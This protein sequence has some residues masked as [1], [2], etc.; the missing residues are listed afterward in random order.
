MKLLFVEN[1]YITWLWRE[2][3]LRLETDGHD[4]HWLVQNPI[5]KPDMGTCHV[6]SFPRAKR[7]AFCTNDRVPLLVTDRAVRYFGLTGDHHTSYQTAIAQVIDA[8]HPDMIFGEPTEFHELIAVAEA[9]RRGIPFLFPSST[10]YPPGRIV[11]QLYDSLSTFGGCGVGLS[12]DDALDLREAIVQRRLVPSY[13]QPTRVAWIT[14][15]VRRIADRARITLGWLAGERFVTPSPWRKI[16]LERARRTNVARWERCAHQALPTDLIGCPLVLY[17]MQVQPESNIDVWGHPWNDQTAIIREAADALQGIGTK[18]VVK[19]NPRSKYEL[20]EDLCR[21]VGTH[22]NIVPLAHGCK[23][24]DVFPHACAVLGVTGTVLL[25]AVLA[26]KPVGV[27]G[28]HPMARYPGVTALSRPSD[29]ALLVTDVLAKRARTAC[30]AEG[31]AL[32]SELHRTSY[33][34]TLFDPL[35]QPELAT[36]ENLDR[37]AN[38]FRDVIATATRPNSAMVAGAPA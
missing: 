21:L 37:I 3:A 20:S 15:Q 33:E 11:F 10:R 28:T 26:G 12:R 31:A 17:A 6:L 35:N 9:R 8:Q 29:I 24:D 27:L 34:G 1:R 7:D 23:M 5:F 25:E 19:P 13:M 2:V 30:P 4:I 38:A 14:R 36:A 18:L 32:L 22:P 16:Q